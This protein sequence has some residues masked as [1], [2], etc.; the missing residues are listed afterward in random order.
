MTT[1]LDSNT[2]Q[3]VSGYVARVQQL[4]DFRD[5]LAHHV[6]EEKTGMRDVGPTAVNRNEHIDIQQAVEEM[7]TAVRLEFRE[8]LE[9]WHASLR[10]V[11]VER[12]IKEKQILCPSSQR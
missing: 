5:G 1:R 9:R 10:S 7:L 2:A 3:S 12:D 6:R 4:A 8:A 11:L